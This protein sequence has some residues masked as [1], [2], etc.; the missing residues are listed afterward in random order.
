[1]TD[2]KVVVYVNMRW[3]DFFLA[4]LCRFVWQDPFF[5]FNT[6]WRDVRFKK[7]GEATTFSFWTFP[8]KRQILF[9]MGAPLNTSSTP[10]QHRILELSFMKPARLESGNQFP[11]VSVDEYVEA[12][13]PVILIE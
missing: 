5:C 13:A 11:P 7:V 8:D 6:T 4:F 9:Y 3:V 2:G 10:D 12:A 1:M